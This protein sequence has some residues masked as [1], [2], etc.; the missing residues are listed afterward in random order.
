ML[1]CYGRLPNYVVVLRWRRQ[2]RDR[3]VPSVHHWIPQCP[4]GWLRGGR[5][6][7]GGG[8]VAQHAASLVA[9]NRRSAAWR[10]SYLLQDEQGQIR[11]TQQY[12]GWTGLSRG[13]SGVIASSRTPQSGPTSLS[14]MHRRSVPSS[15]CAA[16]RNHSGARVG[17]C[18]GACRRSAQVCRRGETIVGERER[19]WDKRHGHRHRT[20]RWR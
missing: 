17:A 12:F 2:Q 1:G 14:T 3:N 6:R 5:Q 9:G 11:E 8:V 15:S 10:Q 13:W 18:R 16:Q 19:T 7:P 20:S 4:T